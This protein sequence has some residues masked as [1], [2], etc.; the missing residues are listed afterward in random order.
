MDLYSFYKIRDDPFRRVCGIPHNLFSNE[1]LRFFNTVIFYKSLLI[2]SYANLMFF[3][4][5]EMLKEMPLK[6]ILGNLES[7]TVKI[8]FS[9]ISVRKTH[10]SFLKS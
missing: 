3:R 5:T 4:K 9:V 10:E 7:K 6:V 8:S 2:V 1:F